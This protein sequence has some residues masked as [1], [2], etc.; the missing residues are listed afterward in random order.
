VES[1]DGEAV[2]QIVAFQSSSFALTKN[3]TVYA[4]GKNQDGELALE[5]ENPRVFRP[6][7]MISLRDAPVNK[8]E[9]KGKT[10]IAYVD[11]A[12]ELTGEDQVG[13]FDASLG[14]PKDGA[15]AR[16]ALEGEEREVFEGVDLM[17]KVYDNTQE[18]WI[19]LLDI[20]HGMPYEDNPTQKDAETDPKGTEDQCSALQLDMHVSIE[21]L[22]EA[23]YEIDKLI[24][25]AKAQI[26]EIR[27]KRGTKNVNFML[28]MFIDDCKL[29]AEKIRRT[30]TSR[31]LMDLKRAASQNPPVMVSDMK[32]DSEVKRLNQANDQLQRTLQEVRRRPTFDVFTRELQ[33]SLVETIE[34]KL[35]V[36]ETQIECI[37]AGKK[38]ANPINASLRT[39]KERWGALKHFSI[40][41]LYQE[42]SL[43]GQKYSFSSDE[44]MLAWLVRHSDSRIDQIIH[45]DRDTMVSRD[46]MVP[47]LC[48]ELLVENAEL[49]KMCN[50]YQL[51]VL[52]MRDQKKQG[53][54]AGG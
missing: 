50:T 45:M 6:E 33:Q 13:G 21:K 26:V 4:W 44:E 7:P 31:A 37:K 52:L 53:G 29:R 8:L 10:I 43:R 24:R 15:L 9:I 12:P 54:K 39:I 20:R 30:I 49:R 41:N 48:Y 38:E 47:A 23:C 14:A 2:V 35:Q 40:F 19:Y 22:E 3:G 27:H 17:R 11:L 42:C 32:K 25:S 51:K 18:W 1:L 5:T 28:S 36:H 16:S 46:S 34:S